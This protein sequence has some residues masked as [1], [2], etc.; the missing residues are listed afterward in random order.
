MLTRP[1]GS[2]LRPT[3]ARPRLTMARPRP[4]TDDGKTKTKTGKIGL[5]IKTKH[6]MEHYNVSNLKTAQNLIR[7]LEQIYKKLHITKLWN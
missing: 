3:M 6:G 4:K 7:L 5:K 1:A 2:R